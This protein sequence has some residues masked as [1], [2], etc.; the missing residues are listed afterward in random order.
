M[1]SGIIYI[2]H[3]VIKFEHTMWI[4]QHHGLL[5]LQLFLLMPRDLSLSVMFSR[6]LYF[7]SYDLVPT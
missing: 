4:I 2:G 6:L 3:K 1:L 5:F 7:E